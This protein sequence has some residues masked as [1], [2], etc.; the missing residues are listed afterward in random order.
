MSHLVIS[1]D[2]LDSASDVVGDGGAVDGRG[3][4]RPAPVADG[5]SKRLKI[6]DAAVRC[7]ARS[8]IGSTSL[9]S[10]AREAGI[11]RATLYRTFPGG[12]DAV[13]HTTAKTETTRFFAGMA[14]AMAAATSLEDLIV[15]SISESARRLTSSA[16]L[17]AVMAEDPQKI[18]SHV[19]L[20]EMDRTLVVVTDF[21]HPFFA[22]WLEREE[23]MRAAE[24]VARVV[25]TYLATPDEDLDLLDDDDVAALVHR[26]VLPGIMAL[27]P[28]EHRR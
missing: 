9:D 3:V 5:A 21:A 20:G 17:N 13:L 25:L 27:G 7:I 11:S 16:A 8:G 28:A 19:S 26:F 12:R 2:V 14:A 15:R 4:R 10:I 22:Q 6:V 23:A 18:L 24:F 1:S